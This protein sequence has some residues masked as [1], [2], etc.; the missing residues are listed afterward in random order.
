MYQNKLLNTG[1]C[2]GIIALFIGIS[3]IPS[4]AVTI[5]EKKV[6]SMTMNEINGL[7]Y[8]RDDDPLN[9][10]D[11]GSLLRDKPQ[12]E[13]V[14]LCGA[15]VLFH[16]AEQG[17]YVENYTINNIYY[18]IWQK[19]PET[20]LEGEIFDL[21]YYTSSGHNGFLNESIRVNT[22]D[23]IVN[24]DN[25]R[26]IQAMQFP[27][28]D[29]AF[30][31]GAEIYNFTIKSLGYSPRIRTFPNQYSFIIL[32]LEDN[33]TLQNYDRDGDNLNDFDELFIY[34]TN[35][36]DSDTDNDGFSD[37]I[38]ANFGTDPNSSFEYPGFNSPPD[39][40]IVTGPTSGKIGN[41]YDYNI[42]ITDHDG[43]PIWY[44]FDWGDNTNTGWLG[45][46][47]SGS[48]VSE[49]HIWS[50]QGNYHLKIKA[51]DS[52][53]AESLWRTLEISM[54]RVKASSNSFL[55]KFLEQFPLLEK[56]LLLVN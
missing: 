13:E 24:V 15:G 10:L 37:Y 2:F 39:M 36:F 5:E 35:P 26:L 30:F 4:S 55:L 11:V 3:I 9:W 31:R 41:S 32:N 40:P 52:H 33:S 49:S 43:D 38:E 27:N 44:W 46:Y 25:Y 51:K 56:L 8:L 20:P 53:D 17:S 42:I 29:I 54:S 1:F 16:F 48:E 19:T 21:G 50:T 7:Y 34:Y 6:N 12:D 45:P 18:H 47:P 22:S 23:Y 28:P 14:T